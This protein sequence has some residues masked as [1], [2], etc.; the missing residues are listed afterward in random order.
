MEFDI[1]STAGLHLGPQ[2][3]GRTPRLTHDGQVNLGIVEFGASAADQRVQALVGPDESEEQQ[4]EASATRQGLRHFGEPDVRRM[5]MYGD[6][7]PRE[8]ALQCAG[9]RVA[10]H[11]VGLGL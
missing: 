6:G 10:L 4:L 5:G 8:L 1:G 9:M 3:F 7:F 11:Q 2:L